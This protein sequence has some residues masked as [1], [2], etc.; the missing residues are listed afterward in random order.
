MKSNKEKE[1][2]KLKD[3]EVEHYESCDFDIFKQKF[4]G[5]S[6][7]N[8]KI[9]IPFPYYNESIDA[10][11]NNDDYKLYHIYKKYRVL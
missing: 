3:I 4:K 2:I 8:K 7:Q 6:V 9:D 10:S 1:S 5:L 11:K